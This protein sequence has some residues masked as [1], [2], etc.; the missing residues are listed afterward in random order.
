MTTQSF[1]PVFPLYVITNDDSIPIISDTGEHECLLAYTTQ[2]LA[3][4]YV[5]QAAEL[6]TDKLGIIAIS[7][8]EYRDFLLA[9]KNDV[10]YI[11]LNTTIRPEYFRLMAITEEL[12]RLGASNELNDQS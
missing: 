12:E 10:S 2:E 7:D 8:T 9:V 4:L 3:E 1:D 11:N 6:S 5:A